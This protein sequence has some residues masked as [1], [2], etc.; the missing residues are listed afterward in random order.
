MYVRNHV[1]HK[2]RLT[3]VSLNESLDS[4][5]NK[6]TEGKFL[7]LPVVDNG[8]FKG[9]ILKETIYR[10]YF[11]NDYDNKNEYLKN[12]KV[13]DI[14][15]DEYR[16]INK[17]ERIEKA[18]YLLK[19]LS[20]PF[21]PVLDSNGDFEGILTHKA[22]FNAFSE[23]YGL[24]EGHRIVINL[25]DVPGQLARLTDFLKNKKVNIMNLAIVD[26]KIMG[27]VRVILR[28]NYDNVDK[29][30]EELKEDGFKVVE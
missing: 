22:I 12:T 7:S 2:D 3:T 29:L 4:A 24:E 18:S 21:L 14:Y 23:V 1:L 30:I 26:P 10:N 16:T 25:V 20:I 5:L 11:D 27:V 15:L 9:I 6:I 8:E 19:E 28:I 17:N 13:R